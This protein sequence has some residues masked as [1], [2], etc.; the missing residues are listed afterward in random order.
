MF[1]TKLFI[2]NNAKVSSQ[3]IFLTFTKY[4]VVGGREMNEVI[5]LVVVLII[6]ETFLSSYRNDM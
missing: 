5:M 6:S 2:H 3:V 4:L 1:I